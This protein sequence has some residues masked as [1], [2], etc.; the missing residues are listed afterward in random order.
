MRDA[1][2][3]CLPIA[4][5]RACARAMVSCLLSASILYSVATAVALPRIPDVSAALGVFLTA[6]LPGMIVILLL[7]ARHPTAY[8]KSRRRGLVA[9]TLLGAAASCVFPYFS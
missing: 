2:T 7:W 1:S 9:A 6:A 5:A 8:S 3:I 4:P